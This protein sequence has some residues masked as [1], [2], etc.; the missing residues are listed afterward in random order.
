LDLGIA[1]RL[2]KPKAEYAESRANWG[3]LL[4]NGFSVRILFRDTDIFHFEIL[5][6]I[7]VNHAAT[8]TGE[9]GPCFRNA[10]LLRHIKIARSLAQISTLPPLNL[11]FLNI[12]V[13]RCA[14]G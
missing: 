2:R 8:F 6:A 14:L 9:N 4:T 5:Y 10:A 1:P 12:S 3:A 7:P 11:E 13:D